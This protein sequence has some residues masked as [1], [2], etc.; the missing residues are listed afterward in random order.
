MEAIRIKEKMKRDGEI[1][2]TGLPFKKGQLIEMIV[3]SE[4]A[5]KR[6]KPSTA[7]QLL[8]SGIVGMWK[9]RK[10]RDS[11]AYA[12]TLREKAQNRII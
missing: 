3:M 6:T 11:A 8:E 4:T 1:Q 7:R 5:G 12:H 10:I 2:L 9:D